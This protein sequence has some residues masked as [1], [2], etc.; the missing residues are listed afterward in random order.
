MAVTLNGT[1]LPLPP[2]GG[3]RHAAK[4]R[5]PGLRLPYVER[6]YASWPS[7]VLPSRVGWTSLQTGMSTSYAVSNARSMATEMRFQLRASASN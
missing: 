5:G 6:L 4:R 1:G 2:D 3:R 7:Q